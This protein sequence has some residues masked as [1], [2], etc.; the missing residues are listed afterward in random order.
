MGEALARGKGGG[1]GRG[2]GETCPSSNPLEDSFVIRLS[3]VCLFVRP[4]GKGGEERKEGGGGE[5]GALLTPEA[6]PLLNLCNT[7]SWFRKKKKK[8]RGENQGSRVFMLFHCFPYVGKKRRWEEEEKGGKRGK[9]EKKKA[10]KKNACNLL[11]VS[12][13][14]NHPEREKKEKKKKGGKGGEKRFCRQALGDPPHKSDHT[15]FY[16]G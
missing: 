16:P 6:I 13:A 7:P 8:G 2:K 1:G 14:A 9:K 5:A 4:S 11:K 10:K 15:P 12:T 3:T